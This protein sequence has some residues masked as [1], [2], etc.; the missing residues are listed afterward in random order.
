MQKNG[1]IIGSRHMLEFASILN[2]KEEKNIW[3]N[4]SKDLCEMYDLLYKK[5]ENI[6]WR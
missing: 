4:D 3:Q 6:R 1:L 5:G 2:Q